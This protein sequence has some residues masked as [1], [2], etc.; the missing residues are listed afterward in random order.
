MK[1]NSKSTISAHLTFYHNVS[2]YSSP[3]FSSNLKNISNLMA[4]FFGTKRTTEIEMSY[5]HLNVA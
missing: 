3:M 5:L 4:F 2:N 1:Y